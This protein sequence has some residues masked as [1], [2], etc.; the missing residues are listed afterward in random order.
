METQPQTHKLS[1]GGEGQKCFTKGCLFLKEVDLILRRLVSLKETSVQK[2]EYTHIRI[3]LLRRLKG[4]N[5]RVLKNEKD[6]RYTTWRVGDFLVV[7]RTER[8]QE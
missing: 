4:K 1:V 2:T 3:N 7:L 6:H 5:S 8:K